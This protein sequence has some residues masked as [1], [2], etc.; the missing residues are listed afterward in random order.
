RSI[1]KLES[2]KRAELIEPGFGYIRL[3]QFQENSGRDL[4]SKLR[5]LE[6]T[7][8]KALILDLRN[9]PGGLLDSAVD[10]S[11]K[12][13]EEGKVVVSTN[14]R[15]D[16]QDFIFKSKRK[17]KHLGYPVAVLINGGSASASEIV[18]GALQDHKRA[19]IIG[20][21]SF[22]KGSVQT[23]VP[24]SDGS[25]VRLTT[26]KYFT[27]SNRSIHN[28]GIEPDLTVPFREFKEKDKEP[29]IFDAL[30]NDKDSEE[31]KKEQEEEEVKKKE[32]DNQVLTAL[33]VLKGIVIYEDR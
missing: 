32:Y 17:S 11:E 14:G 5:E 8:L 1:I 16:D 4:E 20:T 23:V 28:E 25:A 12:F 22:G 21:K 7:D 31:E 19:I 6:K 2:I 30:L 10:V 29:D 24:L 27:P 26:S 33:D 13:L 3:V 18:A 9:N 15:A